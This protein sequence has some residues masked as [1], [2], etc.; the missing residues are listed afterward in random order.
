M[1]LEHSVPAQ[2]DR[3]ELM[4]VLTY[5]SPAGTIGV[6]RDTERLGWML[7][8]RLLC[9]M[10]RLTEGRDETIIYGRYL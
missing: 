5:G 2:F 10:R 7:S 1:A 3:F 9:R 6:G 8:R 4:H